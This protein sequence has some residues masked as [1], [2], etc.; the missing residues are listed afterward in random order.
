[1]TGAFGYVGSAAARCLRDAGYKIHS[2]TNR[3]N[4]QVDGITVAPLRFELDYLIA[5][6][7]GLDTFI[8][9]YWIRIPTQGKHFVERWPTTRC[10]LKRPGVPVCAGMFP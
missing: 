1:L 5:Q 10:S 4:L 2:L 3:T 6:M 9:S 7:R 8:D